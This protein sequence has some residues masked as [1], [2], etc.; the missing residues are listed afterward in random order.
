V[1]VAA[2][3]LQLHPEEM[4]LL[5]LQLVLQMEAEA[6]VLVAQDQIAQAVEHTQQP[7]PPLLVQVRLAQAERP[8]EAWQA[9]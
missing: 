2:A 3:V 6:V 9:A 4:V 8:L 1:Q 7:P 5:E